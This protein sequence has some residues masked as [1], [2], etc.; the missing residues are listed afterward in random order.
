[1]RIIQTKYSIFDTEIRLITNKLELSAPVTFDQKKDLNRAQCRVVKV[2]KSA[3]RKDYAN[4]PI[5]EDLTFKFICNEA[6][7][8]VNL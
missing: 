1:M 6:V 5:Q 3:W 7:R 2:T 4:K 8:L